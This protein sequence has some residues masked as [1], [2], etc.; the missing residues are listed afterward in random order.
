[1]PRIYRQGWNCRFASFIRR[2]SLFG[3]CGFY[4]ESG[5]LPFFK[6]R[7]L[8]SSCM[9]PFFSPY[10]STQSPVTGG[11]GARWWEDLERKTSAMPSSLKHKESGALP[12][13]KL[14]KL[15]SSCM[16][17]FFS[18]FHPLQPGMAVYRR[19]CAKEKT[20]LP[21][22]SWICRKLQPSEAFREK[23]A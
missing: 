15:V 3:C 1:M 23:H 20:R 16:W 17:P 8:V 13:F 10:R 6:L 22:G 2:Q 18:P 4:K 11:A 14:R 19:L 12:F 5:A 21:Q 7:K 9:W